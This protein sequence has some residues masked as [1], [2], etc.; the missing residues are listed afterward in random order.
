MT[1]LLLPIL[2]VLAVVGTSVVAQDAPSAVDETSLTRF[3]RDL[4]AMERFRPGYAFWQNIFTSPDGAIAFG[5]VAL[6]NALL[7]PR[8]VEREPYRPAGPSIAASQGAG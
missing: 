8:L 4:R 5:V 7:Y 3:E 2:G 1:R 6:A